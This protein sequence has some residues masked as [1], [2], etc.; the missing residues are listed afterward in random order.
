MSSNSV[1]KLVKKQKTLFLEMVCFKNIYR[2]GT[3]YNEFLTWHS[4][5][6]SRRYTDTFRDTY[7][8]IIKYLGRKI[9]EN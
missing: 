6:P 3:V 4:P 2:N 9:V 5:P 8:I 1:D 7:H